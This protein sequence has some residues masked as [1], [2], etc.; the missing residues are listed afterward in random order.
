[1]ARAPGLTVYVSSQTVI[2]VPQDVRGIAIPILTQS[3]GETGRG[4]AARAERRLFPAAHITWEGPQRECAKE[5]TIKPPVAKAS[6]TQAIHDVRTLADDLPNEL[7]VK[8]L[9]H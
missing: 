3:S 4:I 7:R 2:P 5:L 9:N 6:A 1:M 8:I